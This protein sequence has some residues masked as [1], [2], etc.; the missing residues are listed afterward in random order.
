MTDAGPAIPVL[1]VAGR[2]VDAGPA[3]RVVLVADG[4]L[5]MFMLVMLSLVLFVLVRAL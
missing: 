3:L 4:C 1:A 5:A 2:S